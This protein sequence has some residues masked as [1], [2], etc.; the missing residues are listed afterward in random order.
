MATYVTL[1][2][3]KAR[4][5][6]RGSGIDDSSDPSN[7]DVTTWLEE[8]ENLIVKAL[9]AVGVDLP[10]AATAG[11]S[12]ITAWAIDYP[13]GLVLEAFANAGGDGSNTNGFEE[14]RLSEEFEKGSHYY[15]LS[16]IGDQ[17]HQ[18]PLV[19]H[20]TAPAVEISQ[21]ATKAL[22]G[23]YRGGTASLRAVRIGVANGQL[24]LWPVAGQERRFRLDPVADDLLAVRCM[25][26]L[27]TALRDPH[28]QVSGMMM[29]QAGHRY[30]LERVE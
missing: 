12:I 22:V 16:E 9:T 29:E 30:E 14:L 2:K 26:G 23:T 28:G 3:V 8:G 21:D 20:K 18:S 6:Y 1:A 24:Y 17:L 25:A 19:D 5:P 4:L 11:G 13:V 27:L 10:G 15:D 7:D